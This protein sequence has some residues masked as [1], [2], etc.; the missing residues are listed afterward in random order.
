MVVG[1]DDLLPEIVRQRSAYQLAANRAA[2]LLKIGGVLSVKA[3]ENLPDAAV[4]LVAPQ[5]LPV[6]FGCDRETIGHLDSTRHQFPVKLPERSIFAAH[7]GN[8]FDADF[9]KPANIA[10][11]CGVG[12]HRSSW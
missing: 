4:E 6:S 9:L 2:S 5:Q 3:G 1:R 8:I 7:S 11:S 10:I 12:R